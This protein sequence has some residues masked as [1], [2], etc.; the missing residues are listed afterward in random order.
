M[1]CPLSTRSGQPPACLAPCWRP[2]TGS[3]GHL[4][5]CVYRLPALP[6]RRYIQQEKQ[7]GA[8]GE[9]ITYRFAEQVCTPARAPAAGRHCIWLQ[10][11]R[12]QGGAAGR[13]VGQG[14]TGGGWRYLSPCF[15]MHLD[16]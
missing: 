5:C 4:C 16:A 8:E 2:L 10:W 1:A 6:A 7:Q 14:R 13:L 9:V 3:A 11:R 12:P 15:C